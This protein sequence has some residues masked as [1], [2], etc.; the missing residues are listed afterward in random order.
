MVQNPQTEG[1][2]MSNLYWPCEEKRR[3]FDRFSRKAV[4]CYA[5]MIGVYS[6][7]IPSS[8]AMGYDGV[9]RP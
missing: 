4:A 1:E 5:L 9:M 8:I 2:F 6:V 3:G 7:I